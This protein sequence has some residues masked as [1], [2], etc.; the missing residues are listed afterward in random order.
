[1]ERFTKIVIWLYRNTS[2][3]ENQQKHNILLILSYKNIFN[4]EW[5]LQDQKLVETKLILSII[6]TLIRNCLHHALL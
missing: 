5:E 4:K 1:M 3:T 2:A 6:R